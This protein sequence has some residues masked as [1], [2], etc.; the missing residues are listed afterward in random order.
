ML[1]LGRSTL[2]QAIRDD[3]CPLPVIRIGR[4]L[5]IPRAALERLGQTGDTPA[6]ETAPA[7]CCPS[8]GLAP[9]RTSPTWVA[10]FSSSSPTG[11]V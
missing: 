4:Q 6:A 1:G 10:A 9:S 7:Q 11:S 5:R 8:C 3:N 2:Y